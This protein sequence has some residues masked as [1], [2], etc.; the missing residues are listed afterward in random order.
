MSC[1]FGVC[2]EDN[3][4]DVILD[5]SFLMW[6]SLTDESCLERSLRIICRDLVCTS[7]ADWRAR[8]ADAAAKTAILALALRSS[9][10][11]AGLPSGIRAES[12]ICCCRRCKRALR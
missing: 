6:S 12:H 5:V 8:S 2:S 7:S 1:A 3:W 11:S 10:A 4:R 9:A